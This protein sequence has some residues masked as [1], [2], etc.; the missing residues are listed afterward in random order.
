M[1]SSG[2]TSH[3]SS[4][5]VSTILHLP[6]RKRFKVLDIADR[7][8]A[9][10]IRIGDYPSTDATGRK[11]QNLMVDEFLFTLRL[12]PF[13]G[14]EGRSNPERNDHGTAEKRIL[15]GVQKGG[16]RVHDEHGQV[17]E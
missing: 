7:I 17:A 9:H 16:A 2:Y 8:A 10:P 1:P 14:H 13:G 3:F 12:P 5:A 6:G 4:E 15:V 11:V